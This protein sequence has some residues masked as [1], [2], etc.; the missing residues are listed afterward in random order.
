MFTKPYP[1]SHLGKGH[2]INHHHLLSLALFLS[3]YFAV[4]AL[5][6]LFE[7]SAEQASHCFVFF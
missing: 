2:R 1:E 3:I 6:A 5:R 4:V 7:V